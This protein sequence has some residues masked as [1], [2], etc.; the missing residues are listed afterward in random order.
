[1]GFEV[2]LDTK[3]RKKNVKK[4]KEVGNF[5]KWGGNTFNGQTV[6]S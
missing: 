6:N 5:I 4:V 2:F 1:M 3:T